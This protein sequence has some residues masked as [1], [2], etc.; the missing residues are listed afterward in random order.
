MSIIFDSAM[1]YASKWRNK[2]HEYNQDV[3][4][5]RRHVLWEEP[6]WNKRMV[7]W[8]QHLHSLLSSCHTDRCSRP[9]N[10]RRYFVISF[11]TQGNIFDSQSI[12]HRT[13]IFPCMNKFWVNFE[14]YIFVH[15]LTKSYQPLKLKSNLNSKLVHTI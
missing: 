2:A 11:W 9:L 10:R 6:L 13:I 3:L 5:R 8:C 7:Q 4:I 14:C 15:V 1:I 12:I